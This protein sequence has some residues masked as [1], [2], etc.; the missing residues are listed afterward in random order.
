MLFPEWEPDP[1][2]LPGMFAYGNSIRKAYLC[3]AKIRGIAPGDVLSFYRSKDVRGLTILAV[4]E[5]V[6]R[7]NNPEEIASF[8][9]KRTV[10]P[11]SEIAEL[12]VKEV[13]SILFRQVRLLTPSIRLEELQANGVLSGAPQSITECKEA[14]KEWLATRLDL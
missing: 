9:G 6:L 3:R 8:V 13:I 10:Y 2:L 5:G 14:G 1:E 7:S 12:A 4:V 11:Y